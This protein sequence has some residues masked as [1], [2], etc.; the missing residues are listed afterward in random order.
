MITP[1]DA[2]ILIV[3]DQESNVLLLQN[4]L[5]D[6]GYAHF[7]TTRDSSQVASLMQEFHPD[8]ILLDLMMPNLDGY[9]VMEQLRPLIPPD[10][11]LP[12]LVLTADATK[13]AKQRALSLGAK[14]FLTKPLDQVEVLLRIKNL[15]ETRLL[16]LQQQRQNLI[17]EDTVR[18]RT[19]QIQRQLQR[20]NALRMIDTAISSTF[21]LRVTLNFLL[22]QVALQLGVDAAAVLLL[23]R[24]VQEL[25]FSAEQG[26]RG[27]AITSVRLRLG[28]DYAGR[29]ALERHSIYVPSITLAQPQFTNPGLMQDEGFV[30][31]YAAPLVA[32]GKVTGVLEIFHRSPLSPD[33]EWSDFLETL[34]GQTAI[35]IDNAELFGDLQQS[36]A[37]MLMAYDRTIEG[38]SRAMDLR[39]KETEGHTLRVTDMTLELARKMRFDESELPHVRRGALLHDMGKL[40]VPDSILLKPGKLTDEEWVIMRRHPTYAYEMLSPVAYLKPAIDIPYCHHEKWDGTGYPRGL[41]GDQ[42]PRAARIFA[43]IDVWDALMSDR[44]YRKAWTREAA[45]RHISKQAGTHFDPEVVELFLKE[46]PVEKS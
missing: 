40:G 20:L 30:A 11:Y 22:Q 6:A 41:K 19:L 15:L 12:I 25:R 28:E 18:E 13:Q 17:L 16:H 39:D 33:S 42:I 38:W 35:A 14:D 3:D 46:V 27:T 4:I 24:A 9:A 37:E 36:N 44:P 31:Y 32:K 26:F 43:V 2:R 1:L 45:L 7:E 29:V 34:A 10:T 8:L 23:D 21:D 5:Q